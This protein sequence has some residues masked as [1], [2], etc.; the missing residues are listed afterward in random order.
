MGI[1]PGKRFRIMRYGD[2]IELVPTEPIR[3]LF[4]FLKGIDTN[5]DRDEDRDEE[6]ECG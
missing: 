2:R 4:G 3:N 6:R 5:I 1:R